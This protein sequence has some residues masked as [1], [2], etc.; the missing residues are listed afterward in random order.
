M[1]KSAKKEKAKVN[2]KQHLIH[3]AYC[4]LIIILLIVTSININRFLQSRKVLGTSIDVSP[5]QNE[6]IYWQ[7]IVEKNPTYV[8]GYLELAKV[9]VEL[10]NKNEAINSIEKALTLNPNSA[11]I[12]EVQK[13]LGL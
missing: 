10:G 12:T 11:K 6:K 3:Y 9:D 5:L 13:Q 4:L 2:F 8:D 1:P 7:G